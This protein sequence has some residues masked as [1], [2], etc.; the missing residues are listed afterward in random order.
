M[1]RESHFPMEKE[2]PV[3]PLSSFDA[4]CAPVHKDGHLVWVF[5]EMRGCSSSLLSSGTVRLTAGDLKREGESREQTRCECILCPWADGNDKLNLQDT[6]VR[7]FQKHSNKEKNSFISPQEFLTWEGLWD[8]L[9]LHNNVR[10]LW[11]N[12]DRLPGQLS[13]DLLAQ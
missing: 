13:K 8:D 3:L 5:L 1:Q 11:F 2:L 6:W 4:D 9:V 10:D 12:L 7:T